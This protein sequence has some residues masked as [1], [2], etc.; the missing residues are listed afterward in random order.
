MPD[1]RGVS[2][3]KDD[4]RLRRLLRFARSHGKLRALYRVLGRLTRGRWTGRC[5]QL[6]VVEVFAVGTAE[7]EAN[8]RPP[9]AYV[10]RRAEEADLPA[11]ESYFDDAERVRKRFRRG[12]VCFVALAKDQIGAAVWVA[13]GPGQYDED[14]DE[15]RS[16][17]RFPAGAC[18]TFDGRGTRLGAWGSMMAHLPRHLKEL[19]VEEVYT[20]IDVD[21][22]MSL[23]SH[24]TLGYRV[25][26]LIG[27]VGLFGISLRGRKPNGKRWRRLPGRL[28]KLEFL[29]DPAACPQDG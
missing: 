5:F 23:D 6:C 9:R 8:R 7:L 10:V 21:N 27:R 24:H 29:T 14:W 12:N 22:Q 26:G 1:N 28:E 11:L 20:Q 17:V 15:L 19:G 16:F 3:R 2:S 13:L 18:W 25:L 4:G